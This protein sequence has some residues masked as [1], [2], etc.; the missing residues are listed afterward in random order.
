MNLTNNVGGDQ[1]YADSLFYACP[2]VR[3]WDRLPKSEKYPNSA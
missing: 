3:A 2:T 1:I